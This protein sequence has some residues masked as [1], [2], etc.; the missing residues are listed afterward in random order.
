MDGYGWWGGLAFGFCEW[1]EL[2]GE[3]ML[4]GGVAERVE[5]C[6]DKLRCCGASCLADG[7]VLVRCMEVLYTPHFAKRTYGNVCSLCS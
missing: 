5:G 3:L 6:G 2:D 4:G 7:E 1:G